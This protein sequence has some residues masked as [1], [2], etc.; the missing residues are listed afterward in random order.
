MNLLGILY[1]TSTANLLFFTHWGWYYLGFSWRDITAPSQNLSLSAMPLYLT[2]C[3]FGNFISNC[4]FQHSLSAFDM[5]HKSRALPECSRIPSNQTPHTL[6]DTFPV[7]VLRPLTLWWHLGIPY[8]SLP[9]NT[10]QGKQSCKKQALMARGQNV[11]T[12]PCDG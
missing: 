7:A 12:G 6:T 5:S 2:D 11:S 4:C 1:D 3:N 9:Q 10:S 8:Q